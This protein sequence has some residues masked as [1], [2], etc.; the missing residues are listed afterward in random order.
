MLLSGKC[1]QSAG[2]P[3]LPVFFRRGWDTTNLNAH[4][5]RSHPS[6]KTR[7]MGHPLFAALLTLPNTTLFPIH[8]FW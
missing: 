7:R 5:R 1:N 2:A 3:S 6:Q 4:C 8:Q